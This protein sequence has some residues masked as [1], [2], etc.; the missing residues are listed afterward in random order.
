MIDHCETFRLGKDI[1]ATV[2]WNDSDAVKDSKM[3]KLK[4]NGKEYTISTEE[5]HTLMM[6]IGSEKQIKDLMPVKFTQVRRYETI[7]EFKWKAS[8]NIQKGEEIYIKA[9]HIVSIP[10]EE[11]RIAKA[12]DKKIKKSSQFL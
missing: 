8:R 10:I 1:E 4:V 9:P 11:E 6:V 3:I 2:N 12:F 7:L 5:L